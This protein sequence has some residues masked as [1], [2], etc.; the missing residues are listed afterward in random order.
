MAMPRSAAV[1]ALVLAL[2]AGL[3]ACG[4]KKVT[5]VTSTVVSKTAQ[6]PP[7]SKANPVS[8]RGGVA[9]A[10]IPPGKKP[11][12]LRT[13]ATLTAINAPGR[14]LGKL[15]VTVVGL[16]DHLKPGFFQAPQVGK[17]DLVAVSITVTNVGA[18]A[19]S[20]SPSASATLITTRGR[21]AGGLNVAGGCVTTFATRL[22]LAPG[23]QQRGC[24]AYVVNRGARPKLFQF[25]PNFPAS[26]AAEWTLTGKKK[27]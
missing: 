14:P 27:K 3:S 4:A 22:E 21:Q 9:P 12:R 24:L 20:G 18:V 10:K 17:R 16:L 19:W 26:P 7:T 25:S 23:E 2:A 8:G 15:R 6:L 1:A 11:Q 5:V 13:S